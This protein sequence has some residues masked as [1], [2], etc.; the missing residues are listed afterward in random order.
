M[1]KKIQ[2]L[3]I[4]FYQRLLKELEEQ[5][6]AG[7]LTE[8]EYQTRHNEISNEIINAYEALKKVKD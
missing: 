6:K 1:A 8:E 5:K 7:N 3:L 2:E 4:E